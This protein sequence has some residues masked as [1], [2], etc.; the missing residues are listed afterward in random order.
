MN[1]TIIKTI[2]A[3]ALIGGATLAGQPAAAMDFDNCTIVPDRS[4]GGDSWQAVDLA[5]WSPKSAASL[6]DV[7]A[8]VY[9]GH[10]EALEGEPTLD[11]ELAP[12]SGRQ[13]IQVRVKMTGYL[14]DS[15]AGEQFLAV[16]EPGGDGWVLADLRKR[17]LCARGSGAGQWT[18]GRFP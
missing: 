11:I 15:V 12:C 5:D 10:P 6:M 2:T 18:A 14:D 8:P 9:S 13:A 3:A 4:P 1:R 7:V 16:V 17:H